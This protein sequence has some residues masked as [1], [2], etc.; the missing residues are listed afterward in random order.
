MDDFTQIFLEM[1]DNTI[2]K[3]SE[4]TSILLKKYPDLGN[5]IILP[6]NMQDENKNIPIFVFSQNPNLQI[7]GNFYNLVLTISS[8]YNDKLE[9]IIKSIFE[10]F[11][12]KNINFVGIACTFQ[13]HIDNGKIDSFKLNHFTNF[14]TID[15]DKIHFSMLR[16]ININSKMT[17]CL[18]GYSTLDGDFVLHFEF[19]MKRKD[20][21]LLDIDY[22]MAFLHQSVE[23]KE[24]KKLC[25]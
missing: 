6:I 13:E 8:E 22:I 2:Y 4:I 17:R 9:K 18:E 25:L 1:E 15:N 24:N 21:E 3:A 12:D 20:F 14:E 23:Y 7:Q 19:N 10:I 5:E 16:E 11:T